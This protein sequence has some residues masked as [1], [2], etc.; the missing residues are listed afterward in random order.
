[1][2]DEPEQSMMEQERPMAAVPTTDPV[3]LELLSR[4][5]TP[6]DI[7]RP[8]TEVYAYLADFARH[9]EWAHTFLAVERASTGKLKP[10]ARL[11]IRERQD[12]RWDKRPFTTIADREGATYTTDVEISALE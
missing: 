9:I 5:E 2:T 6:L 12:L 4:A 1:M 8:A 10:G 7:G 3:D 11:L